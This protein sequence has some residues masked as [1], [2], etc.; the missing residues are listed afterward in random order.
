MGKT[1]ST[2]QKAAVPLLVLATILA[3]MLSPMQSAVNGQLGKTLHGDG[4]ATA[5]ISFGSGLVVMAIIILARQST[6][7][8][9]ASIPRLIKSRQMP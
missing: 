3:G 6:R 1:M 7:H 4:N 5:V 9:F 2:K 8:Q